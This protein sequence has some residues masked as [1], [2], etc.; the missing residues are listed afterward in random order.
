MGGKLVEMGRCTLGEKELGN[1]KS[2]T[3]VLMLIGDDETM[4]RKKIY[5][6]QN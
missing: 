3:Y 2:G 6:A 1:H 4:E 5:L